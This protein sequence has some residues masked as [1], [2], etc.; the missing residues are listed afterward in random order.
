MENTKKTENITDKKERRK[1][2]AERGGRMR[3][4]E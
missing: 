4:K 2:M 1:D 3:R